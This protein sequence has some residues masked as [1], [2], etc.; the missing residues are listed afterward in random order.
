ML[1]MME[2]RYKQYKISKKN[3]NQYLQK[4]QESGYSLVPY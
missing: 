4:W 1:I 2:F 3:I